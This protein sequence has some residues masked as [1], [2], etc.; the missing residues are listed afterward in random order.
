MNVHELKII[1]RP[2]RSGED[3]W[4]IIQPE[5]IEFWKKSI[6]D[7]N[8]REYFHDGC[9]V[10][11]EADWSPVLRKLRKQLKAMHAIYSGDIDAIKVFS[12]KTKILVKIEVSGKNDLSSH[13]WKK[14]RGQPT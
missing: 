3:N 1:F 5:D 14:S 8:R 7:I 6:A 2:G 12:G 4:E 9:R 11:V 10:V 13:H